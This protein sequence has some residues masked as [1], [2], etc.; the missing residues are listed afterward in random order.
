MSSVHDNRLPHNVHL[1]SKR[2]VDVRRVDECGTLDEIFRSCLP[3]FGG[4]YLRRVYSLL[5]QAIGA[6][7]PLTLAIAG[8]VTVSG[9]HQTWLIPLLETGWVAYLSTTDA[10]CYHDGH[11]SLD[12]HPDPIFEVPIFGDDGVLRDEKTIRVTDMA[13]DEDV[14]FQQDRFM[15]ACLLRPEFQKAMTGT[16]LR[17]LLGRI[18]AA[19]EEKNG[20]APGLLA[21][22]WRL[23]VPILVGAPGDGS[24]FLNSMKLWAMRQAGVLDDYEFSLDL[25]AEV[26]ESCAYHYWGLFNHP[27]HSL[28][29]LILGGGV[30]VR[31]PDRERAGDRGVP[32]LL[33]A[34]RGR[35]L[36]EGRPRHLPV[37]HRERAG[38]LLD[39]DA[40]PGQGAARQPRR[41]RPAGGGDR[42]GGSVPGGAQGGRLPAP[43]RGVPPLRAAGRPGRR[44]LPER[45]RQRGVAPEDAALSPGLRR[46]S[47]PMSKT[48]VTL[49]PGDGIGPE[50]SN[51]TV[52]V[53]DAA[54]ADIEWERHIAGAE[55]LEKYGNPLPPEVLESVR[56]NCLALKGPITTQVGKGFKS[57]NVQ[58]RQELDL[59]ANLR[60]SRSLPSIPSRFEGVDIIVV[61]ENTED[62]Y[63]GLEHI[64]VPGVVESLKIITEKASLRIARF[65][66]EYA[67]RHHRKRVTA[68]HKANIMKLSDGLFL[69]CVRRVAVEYP[70]IQSDDKIVDNMCMQLVMRPEEWDVLLLENL[71]GDIVSDLCA[72]LV[73]GLGV[74]PGGNIGLDVAIFEAVHGSAP[75]IA[76]KDLANPLALMR[77]GIMMLYHMG[78]DEVAERVRRALREVVVNRRI[79]TR[80]LG[81]EA[82][83][84]Q[85]TDAIV[86][87]I[88]KDTGASAAS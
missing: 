37:D 80:D 1:Q 77:S 31:R 25:H 73:G 79:R 23:G 54:G 71:Y 43:A 46:K 66:Y 8:P 68:V 34:G 27:A 78:K 42:G 44:A 84:T 64:V 72:G 2:R 53:L 58:L 60:P 7:C 83:T 87:A 49:I 40:V 30:H 69:D 14:L 61:R 47:Q 28:A 48:T 59:Y 9:Q 20:V 4:A 52:R 50:V 6:G 88:E 39:G 81:G 82:T 16:E 67:R 13:F 36:G 38:R 15:T 3:A 11:R 35:D 17:Y 12:E 75:D 74:V 10:V 26:F 56:R 51:A 62:L 24:L 32:L 55:A 29:T 41:L 57:I 86:D 85:F 21:T 70:E 65:A 18:Y 5:D 63:A 19:Q 22:C 33:P 76:G 45:V